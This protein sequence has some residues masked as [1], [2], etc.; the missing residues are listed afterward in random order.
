MID[1]GAVIL[2]AICWG[3]SGVAAQHLF[4][5]SA[6]TAGDL[7]VARLLL[8][9]VLFW[10]PALL[11]GKVH[12]LAGTKKDR[13]W[14]V[15]VFGIVGILTVQ[16]TYFASIFHGNAATATVLQY[17]APVLIVLYLALRHRRLPNAVEGLGALLAVVGVV[18]MVSGG[19]TDRLIVPFA[20]VAWGLVSALSLAFYTLYPAELLKKFRPTNCLVPECC[21]AVCS[22]I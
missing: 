14:R 18:L 1:V 11:R 20:G 8:S 15:P 12:S 3:L 9:G 5:V 6:M 10:V 7:T 17:L 2:A 13:L 16:F 4:V 19:R 21:G 22:D